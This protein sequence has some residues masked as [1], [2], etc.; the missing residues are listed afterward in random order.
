[1][2]HRFRK[3]L[4]LV[5]ISLCVRTV[6]GTAI[7]AN[8]FVAIPH[9]DGPQRSMTQAFPKGTQER[10]SAFSRRSEPIAAVSSVH[11]DFF[12]A[13]KLT[14]VN[15]AAASQFGFSVAIDDDTAVVG[16]PGDADNKGAALIYRRNGSTW[17]LQQKIVGNDSVADDN[18]GWSVAISGE[19]IVVGAFDLNEADQGSAYVFVR[20]GSIWN[21]QQ[22]LTASGGSI[23]DQFGISVSID[24]DTVVVG[25]P[26]DQASRGAAYVY[27]R[28][29][30]SWTQQQKLI[31]SDAAAGDDL[32]WSAAING[33][34]VLVGAPSDDGSRGG[35]YV[36][37]RNGAIWTQQSKV[38]A[39]DGA[40]SDRFGY[41]VAVNGSYM[42]SG[43]PLTNN[44]GKLTGSAYVFLRTGDN[45]QQQQ[46][47]LPAD[48]EANDK[49]GGAV[50]LNDSTAVIG[51]NADDIGMAFDKGSVY[52]F[53]RVQNSWSQVQKL[54]GSDAAIGD[55]F[56]G[57]VAVRPGAI[58]VG[59]YLD[60]GA[61]LMDAGSAFV[62]ASTPAPV[63]SV[64]G[65][66]LTPDGR[67]LRSAK[68][69]I[70]DIGL[71]TFESTV[72]STLG[73]FQFSVVSGRDY[74]INVGAKRYRFSTIPISVSGDV[75]DIDL[76]GME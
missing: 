27:A 55:N 4:S 15:P 72:T 63:V 9:T 40:A 41:S 14:D 75:T 43:A 48:G 17:S 45:W 36:F 50:A 7:V 65:K 73:Y 11:S 67:G 28:S 61:S 42:L 10:K 6:I 74:I 24:G 69:T 54:E 70:T 19:T 64:S 49:F 31:A 8:C 23:T 29:G 47:L 51:A 52:V 22:K 76:V 16:S 56:G 25:S 44:S 2:S 13:S 62:F 5:T 21:Q 34:T 18:F 59:S 60:D 71:G 39:S 26:G 3:T 20:G 37:I 66:V 53:T 12:E 30:T 58:I 68:V 35:A 57:S 38:T 46:E 32:G 1:M 33:E